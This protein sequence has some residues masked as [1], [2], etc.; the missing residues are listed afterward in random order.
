ME[1]PF[2]YKV[3]DMV[4]YLSN[5]KV[6]YGFVIDIHYR[7]S[8]KEGFLRYRVK[9]TTHHDSYGGDEMKESELFPTREDLIAHL[10]TVKELQ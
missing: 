9:L 3:N 4:W 7:S 6:A 1:S 2:K 10:S 5:N 8:L